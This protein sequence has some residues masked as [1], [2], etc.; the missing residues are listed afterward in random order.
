MKVQD[1]SPCP[2]GV[3]INGI[4]AARIRD[5]VDE[6]GD[7]WAGGPDG[8]ARRTRLVPLLRAVLRSLRLE[9][10]DGERYRLRRR[11][12]LMT[13]ERRPSEDPSVPRRV[14]EGS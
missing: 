2:I 7:A 14:S 6:Y 10:V 1:P 9:A 5:L 12:D 8:E 13:V 4:V 11:G 3:S